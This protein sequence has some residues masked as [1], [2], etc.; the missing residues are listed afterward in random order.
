MTDDEKSKF[1]NEV[2]IHYDWGPLRLNSDLPNAY[3]LQEYIGKRFES[4]Q[5]LNIR[6][7]KLAALIST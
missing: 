1:L 2:K 6:K 5:Y 4:K 3:K 7:A